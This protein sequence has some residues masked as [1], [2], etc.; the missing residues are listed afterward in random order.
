MYFSFWQANNWIKL[1]MPML[2]KAQVGDGAIRLL[3]SIFRILVK[4]AP[5]F[6][7]VSRN[8]TTVV[9]SINEA[10]IN[11]S[12]KHG[13]LLDDCVETICILF[14]TYPGSC[15]SSISSVE[16]LLISN[17]KPDSKL[18]SQALA[19]CLSLI[20]RLGGGGKE[21]INHKANFVTMFQKLSY[22]LEDLMSQLFKVIEIR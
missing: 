22:T 21:G 16:K 6:P 12:Q 14:K 20:P 10:L 2:Q 15:G 17:V 3:C 18:S 7:D 4:R 5:N 8:L 9:A 11:V 19:K 1:T 13:H